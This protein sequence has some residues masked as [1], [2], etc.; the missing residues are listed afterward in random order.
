MQLETV[1]AVV[2]GGVSGLGLAVATHLVANGGKVALF[3]VNDDKGADA[4][5]M[6]GKDSARYFSTDVTDEEG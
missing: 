1:R 2:T 6:L 4:V 3:D 5:A